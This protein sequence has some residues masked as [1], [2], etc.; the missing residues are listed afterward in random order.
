M[1]FWVMFGE[2]LM[3]HQTV[4][5][6]YAYI[7][8]PSAHHHSNRCKHFENK[9]GKQKMKTKNKVIEIK[10]IQNFVNIVFKYVLVLTNLMLAVLFQV[11]SILFF[12]DLGTFFVCFF[13]YFPYYLS[14]ARN[15]KTKKWYIK[16]CQEI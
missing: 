7:L 5:K 3:N 13:H 10:C 1:T 12:L 9:V 2:I 16:K 8:Y 15:K 11:L 14:C 4:G 6:K